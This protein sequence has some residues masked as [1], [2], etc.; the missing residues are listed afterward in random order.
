[1]K[2]NSVVSVVRY[3]ILIVVKVKQRSELSQRFP[4]NSGKVSVVSVLND[5]KQ[6]SECSQK[7]HFNSSKSK[8][9]EVTVVKYFILVVV[10]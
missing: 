2:K 1:M 4:F 3:F 10:K 9:T 5:E 8:N 6:R 7:F